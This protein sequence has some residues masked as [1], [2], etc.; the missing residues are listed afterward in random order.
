MFEAM[1]ALHDLDDA[2]LHQLSRGQLVDTFA[3]EF[4]AALGDISALGSQQVGNRFQGCGFT[5]AVGSEQGDDALLG[6]LERYAFQYQDDVIVDH[7]DVIYRQQ[8]I[9]AGCYRGITHAT[10]PWYP[11]LVTAAFGNVV[12][13]RVLGRILGNQR[14]GNVT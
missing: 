12:F 11:G 13:R 10:F 6:N 8:Y 3:L 1:P 5:G 4:D 9:A 2:L 14:A 7:L